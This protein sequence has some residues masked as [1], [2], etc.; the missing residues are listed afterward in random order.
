MSKFSFFFLATPPIKVK[1]HLRERLLIANHLDQSLSSTNHK[2]WAS[3]RFNLLHSFL[4]V[5]NC[6]ATFTSHWKL[7]E[8]GAEKPISWAKLTHFDFSAVC[9]T[10][11]SH[12]LRTVG[13]A[14]SRY[15][16]N[17]SMKESPH[18]NSLHIHYIYSVSEPIPT[19]IWL[20]IPSHHLNPH[21]LVHLALF[22]FFSPILWY[23]QRP[24]HPK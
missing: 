17:L 15:M 18:P 6:I 10:V 16:L 12:I 24:D 13:D 21:G 2:Y 1:L 5:N 8:F 22:F 11:W 19:R 20:R 7:H 3:V 4:E 9:F 23:S 14:L